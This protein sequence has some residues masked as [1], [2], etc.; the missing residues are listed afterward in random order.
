MTSGIL[1][2]SALS[3]SACG[4]STLLCSVLLFMRQR[5]IMGLAHNMV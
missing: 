4:V 3:C 1:C 2:F 5:D